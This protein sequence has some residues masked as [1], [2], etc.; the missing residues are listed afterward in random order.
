[1]FVVP[2]LVALALEPPLFLLADRYPRHLF[3]RGGLV[4]MAIAAMVCAVAP[5]PIVLA[6]GLSVAAVATGTATGLAQATLVDGAGDARGTVLAR[7][8]LWSLGGD[9]AAPVLLG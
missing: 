2:G 6:A 1:V 8:A 9:L 3:I 5:G 4:A 7:W